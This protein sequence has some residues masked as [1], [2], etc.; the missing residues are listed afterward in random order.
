MTQFTHLHKWKQ[1]YCERW[2]G[3]YKH[4]SGSGR[5]H[6]H[7]TYRSAILKPKILNLIFSAPHDTMWPHMRRLSLNTGAQRTLPKTTFRPHL[8]NVYK[9]IIMHMQMLQMLWK[10]QSSKHFWLP[11]WWLGILKKPHDECYAHGWK[12]LA[13][14]RRACK[15][16]QRARWPQLHS[17]P[18]RK[19]PV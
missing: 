6:R 14:T 15:V 19:R 9:H 7:R 11:T 3:D 2:C 16:M 13:W 12:T 1:Q 4:I 8:Q 18:T 17:L 10:L 5:V